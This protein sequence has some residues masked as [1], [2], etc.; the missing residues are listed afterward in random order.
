MKFFSHAKIPHFEGMFK[1]GTHTRNGPL[2]R[3]T[4]LNRHIMGAIFNRVAFILRKN[5][6]SL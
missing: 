2:Q 3:P 1:L 5:L 6:N 4:L